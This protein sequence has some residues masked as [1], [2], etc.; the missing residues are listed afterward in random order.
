MSAKTIEGC[1]MSNEIHYA[2][3]VRIGWAAVAILAV[4]LVPLRVVE[5]SRNHQTPI[6]KPEKC[7]DTVLAPSQG[8]SKP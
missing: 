5:I 3:C 6:F 7:P 4:I 8:T 2:W 1:P